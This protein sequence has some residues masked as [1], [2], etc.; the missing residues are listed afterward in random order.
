MKVLVT[1]AAGFI[2]FHSAV[3]LHEQGCEVVGIDNLNSYY[4]PALKHARLAALGERIRFIEGDFADPEAFERIAKA[5]APEVV[6]H[7]GAQAGVR[8]SIDA[9]FAYAHSNLTG[10]LS[11]LE[12]CRR[13]PN[14]QRLVYAS[15]S[16]VYG[17]NTKTP[18][19]E[20]DRVDDPVSL[21]AATKRCD[22]LMSAAYA[23][24][25]GFEQMGLRFLTVYGPWGR[26]DMAYWS[27]TRDIL[28]GR[29]IRV[30]NEGR[31][32]R[33]FTYIDD[34]V[35]GVTAACLQ[36][37][38]GERPKHRVYNIGNNAPVPL[39]DFIRELEGAIGRKAELKFEPMQ[40]GDVVETYADISRI[41][42][43]YGFRP[44]TPLAAGL[45]PFVDWFRNYHER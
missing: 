5:E 40:P 37:P 33:D 14:L 10:H 32:R 38:S 15:S 21:Y 19:S 29:P 23:N 41:S 34:I 44:S 28:D 7:L 36:T 22:E 42:A 3:R 4:D 11:V 16:S 20:Y 12:A 9:P 1:G 31:M 26:P 18:F 13:N 25:Y 35:T 17:G 39:L 30:F 43:D 8:H 27:F 6:L 2:G 24:L 45:P